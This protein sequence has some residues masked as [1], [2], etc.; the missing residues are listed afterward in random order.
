MAEGICVIPAQHTGVE[1]FL[2]VNG[3]VPPTDHVIWATG[4]YRHGKRFD[5][6]LIV[7]ILGPRI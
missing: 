5:L 7:A 4:S 3:Y 2:I 6:G 1:L